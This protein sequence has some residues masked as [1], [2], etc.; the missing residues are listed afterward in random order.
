MEKLM[1]ANIVVSPDDLRQLALSR[2]EAVKEFLLGPGK[3]PPDRVFLVDPAPAAD[4][5]PGE[6]LTRAAFTLK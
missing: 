2:A 5:K 1:L 4:P 3:V 6:S